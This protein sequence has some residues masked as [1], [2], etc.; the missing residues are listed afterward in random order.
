MSRKLATLATLAL[1]TFAAAVLAPSAAQADAAAGKE[2]FLAKNCQSCHG[3]GGEGNGPLAVTL[4]PKPRNF[5]VGDFKFDPSGDGKPGSD[6]DLR[7]VIKQGGAAFGGSPMM[8][9][10][11]ALTDDE[12]ET[13][14]VYIRSLKK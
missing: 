14:I 10:N 8:M 13:I 9:P 7:M 11:P 5:T 6:D 12:I 2:I 3:D 1:G 4:D